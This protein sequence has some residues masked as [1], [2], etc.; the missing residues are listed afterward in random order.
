MPETVTAAELF[1]LKGQVAIV[2]GAASGIGRASAE[3]LA[4]AGAT[5]IAASLPSDRPE[6]AAQ[7]AR[8]RGLDLESFACDVTDETQLSALVDHVL[9]QHG[10]ID[11]VFCN[12]GVALDTGPHTVG[13]DSELDLMF[14]IHVR[15]VIKL[16]NLTIPTM[17]EQGGGTFLIMSSLSGVRGNS[18]LGQ[19]GVTKAANAQLARN[20][21]VQWGEQNIRVNSLSPGVI[22][23]AFAEPITSNPDAAARRLAKTPMR[24][25]G[26]PY[27][28]AGA[29]VWLASKAGS[30]TSGQNIIIDGGTVISD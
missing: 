20:L 17:A 23:T 18:F 29:V 6:G 10:R 8:L 4:S 12:A 30:F 7:E 26:E 9:D 28:V 21:A 24:R 5:V 3:L 27:H 13:T 14:D 15:S 1:S 16:A 19:Y 11:T 22:A 2:T 25:F